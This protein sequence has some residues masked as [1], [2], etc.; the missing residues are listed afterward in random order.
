MLNL[1]GSNCRV[2]LDLFMKAPVIGCAKV[3]HKTAGPR[4]AVTPGRIQAWVKSQCLTFHDANQILLF[5]QQL[6]FVFIR[7]PGQVQ[8]VNFLILAEQGIVRRPEHRV[9]QD[10]SNVS[11]AAVRAAADRACATIGNSAMQAKY[12]AA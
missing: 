3:F 4:T 6:E 2:H 7:D 9:P 12:L 5:L 10:A 8:A 1:N 11:P